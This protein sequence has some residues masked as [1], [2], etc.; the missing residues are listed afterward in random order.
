MMKK[1]NIKYTSRIIL[2]SS[3]CCAESNAYRVVDDFNG[4]R[5]ILDPLDNTNVHRASIFGLDFNQT[6]S[7]W[8]MGYKNG[9]Y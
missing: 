2:G 5:D 1:K 9:G 3:L 7:L 4:K 8:D 6:K